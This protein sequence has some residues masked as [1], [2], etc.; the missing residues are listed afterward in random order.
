MFWTNKK[1]IETHYRCIGSSQHLKSKYGS[2]YLL[3]I[4]LLTGNGNDQGHLEASMERLKQH[5]LEKF[6][7]AICMEEFVERA[8]YKIPRDDVTSLARA[9]TVLEQGV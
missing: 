9:F 4:K 5:I 7:G 6:P 2:G 1:Y 3:E 8:Q